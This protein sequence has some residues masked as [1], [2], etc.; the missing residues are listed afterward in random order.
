MINAI[1]ALINSVFAHGGGDNMTN[2]TSFEGFLIMLILY[3]SLVLGIFYDHL[4]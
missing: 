4:L 3:K 2:I 1:K